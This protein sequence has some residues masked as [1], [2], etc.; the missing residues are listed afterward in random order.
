MKSPEVAVLYVENRSYC[1]MEQPVNRR[2]KILN[3]NVISF[4]MNKRMLV[5]ML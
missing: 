2:M 5:I 3:L 1:H 4:I